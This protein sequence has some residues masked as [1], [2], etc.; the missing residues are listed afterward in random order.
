VV[1]EVDQPLIRRL[2]LLRDEGL[3]TQAP[4]GQI[5]PRAVVVTFDD[6]KRYH[7]FFAEVTNRL[8]D[9]GVLRLP[10]NGTMTYFVVQ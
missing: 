9:K 4:G 3:V 8:R 6:A 7:F 10:A 2:A 1:H 5:L